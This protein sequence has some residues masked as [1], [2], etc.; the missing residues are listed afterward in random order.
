MAAATASRPVSRRPT[1]HSTMSGRK[2]S[3]SQGRSPSA[4]LRSRGGDLQDA[5]ETLGKVPI[6]LRRPGSGDAGR[7]RPEWDRWWHLRS[8]D[9]SSSGRRTM[10]SAPRP[11]PHCVLPQSH[12]G[13]Y[14]P[15]HQT[16]PD[17]SAS[18]RAFARVR[19]AEGS[20]N[21]VSISGSMPIPSSR[22]LSAR[23]VRRV[24]PPQGQRDEPTA[25][26]ELPAFPSS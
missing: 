13:P 12:R 3:A 23:R 4:R 22:T 9:R 19:L 11:R 1:S 18:R 17:P 16:S 2:L 26:R 15:A 25:V 5:A 20:N 8:G 7:P 14:Q 10:N 24:V 21:R 6:V